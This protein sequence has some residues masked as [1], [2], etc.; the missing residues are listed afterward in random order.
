[1]TTALIPDLERL[2]YVYLDAH[3]AV[4][5]LGTRLVGRTPKDTGGPWVR[6]TQLDARQQS[7]PTDHLTGFM[8]QF[9]VYAGNQETVW[10]HARTIR[11]ALADMLDA[12][13]S[14]ATVTGVNFLGMLRNPDLDFDP[15]RERVILT[16]EIFAHPA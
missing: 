10:T 16:A 8:I 7:R 12:A 3:P 2:A 13:H 1:M 14:G 4:V 11:A 9:D 6:V 5:A 15:A